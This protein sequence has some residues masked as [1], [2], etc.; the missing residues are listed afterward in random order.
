MGDRTW[1]YEFVGDTIQSIKWLK[2]GCLNQVESCKTRCGQVWLTD[3]MRSV[4][5]MLCMSMQF[6]YLKCIIFLMDEISYKQTQILI[7][8][9]LFLY[10]SIKLE[11]ISVLKRSIAT[12]LTI[13]IHSINKF[14]V[15]PTCQAHCLVPEI[16]QWINQT[17][18][19]PSRSLHSTGKRQI[20][21]IPLG[22]PVNTEG[23][24]IIKECVRCTK[25][26]KERMI[27]TWGRGFKQSYQRRHLWGKWESAVG[28]ELEGRHS[29]PLCLEQREW[30]C[31]RVGD[32]MGEWRKDQVHSSGQRRK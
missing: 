21:Y 24:K 5:Y 23:C 6:G 31:W 20:T 12:K 8:F 29:R 30:G 9:K 28:G 11:Q 19:L 3:F 1:T 4:Q 13:F 15:P 16:L 10:I 14:W 2:E 17:R 27:W 25:E 32:V 7:L 18:W 22:K 26:N